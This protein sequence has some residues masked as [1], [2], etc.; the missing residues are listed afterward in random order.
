MCQ[1]KEVLGVVA[2]K[3]KPEYFN[4]T[5]RIIYLAISEL[6]SLSLTIDVLTI[7]H[8]LKRINGGDRIPVNV[9]SSLF[10]ESDEL[11]FETYLTLLIERYK[12]S[13]LK[14]MTHEVQKALSEGKSSIVLHEIISKF[15]GDIN[16]GINR[17]KVISA[18]G[19]NV[20]REIE[21]RISDGSQEVSN[22]VKYGIHELDRRD[23]MRS[24]N[25]Y[26]FA[27]K[28][29]SGKTSMAIQSLYENCFINKK[30][31][32]FFTLEM[33]DEEVY[34]SF[35]CYHNKLDNETY[36]KMP[37]QTRLSEIKLFRAYLET[38][39]I[40]LIIDGSSQ[41]IEDIVSMI[42][43]LHEQKPLDLIVIDFL[44]IIRTTKKT[45]GVRKQEIDY[46]LNEIKLNVC[47]RFKLPVILISQ[48]NRKSDD[49]GDCRIP[50]MSDLAESSGIEQ[51]ACSIF[52]CH[53]VNPNLK[54]Y[55]DD[56]GKF[57]NRGQTLFVCAKARFSE[58]GIYQSWF[59]GR[60][61]RFVQTEEEMHRL[62]S[63]SEEKC[64]H[65]LKK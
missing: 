18:V 52:F 29:A 19:K 44:Q 39:N 5:N 35:Y 6:Y 37:L 14:L 43:I 1:H 64:Q 61:K 33:T 65:F 42:K 60:I 8:I 24:G 7:Q 58:T 27:G 32:A 57:E 13:Q 34:E 2:D 63:E 51:L 12:Q 16:M 40:Q 10:K 28:P 4:D 36:L 49:K 3:L 11:K 62:I 31:G 47:K 53:R 26:V 56:E 38:N 23:R 30:R 54:P 20:E 59:V 17:P 41:N 45:Y 50:V 21:E 46:F 22:Y 25:I 9:I 15:T 55:F 48:M